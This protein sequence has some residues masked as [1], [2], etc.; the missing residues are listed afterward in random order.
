MRSK[1][2]KNYFLLSLLFILF[3][4][5]CKKDETQLTLLEQSKSTKDFSA[6]LVQEWMKESYAV[7]RER[8]F[9]A[10]DASRLYS[11]TA[12]AM[13][14]SMVN[15]IENGASLEGQLEG[16]NSMPKP[17]KN[18]EYDWGIVLCH[19]TPQVI[20]HMLNNPAEEILRR[21][22][23]TR[24]IQ[25]KKLKE[26]HEISSEV[27]EN[28][29]QFADQIA[30]AIIDYANSDGTSTVLSEPYTMPSTS[31]NPSYYDGNGSA[32]PFF[33]APFWWKSRTFATVSA[34]IC[35][36]APPYEYSEDPSSIY[37][38]DVKEV[39]DATRDPNKLYIGQYWANNPKESGTPAGSWISIGNQLVDQQNLDIIESLKMY[40]L[41]SISTRDTFI[42]VWWTKYKWN[43]QRPVSY[44]RKVLGEPTWTS[45]VPTPPYPDYVSG[46]SANGGSSSEV[47]TYLFGGN[48]PFNDSQHVTK[49]FP[50]RSFTNFKQAGIEAY[51]SRIFAGV[52]MRKACEEGFKLGE[53]VARNVIARINFKK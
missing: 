44:I 39:L 42:T 31:V 46:T 16:L 37:Y 34:K 27:I 11:Y 50:T 2:Q 32:N 21:V 35:E 14:E 20:N 51:H 45:P 23:L 40:L 5:G 38:K 8:G 12:I 49:G 18:K 17:D 1:K 26:D 25:E 30:K 13:Y 9:F 24:Q 29:K 10:L 52:H 36:P 4:V 53:C 7:V 48:K 15:G 6:S 43:L 19:A 33:M 22:D 41:L 3:V 47:L 28:S